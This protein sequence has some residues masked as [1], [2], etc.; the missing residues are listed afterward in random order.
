MVGPNDMWKCSLFSYSDSCRR[1]TPTGMR[2][3][4]DKWDK[5]NK[6]NVG[7]LT[8]PDPRV[9]RLWQALRP[10][11][12]DDSCLRLDHPRLRHYVHRT[13]VPVIVQWSIID[14]H[15]NTPPPLLLLCIYY[16]G[17]LTCNA[18]GC[19]SVDSLLFYHFM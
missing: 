12:N 13:A 14:F 11:G 9:I 15:P 1:K 4:V 7:W 17:S 16:F 5:F 10:S 6:K 19:I 8:R 2:E 3:T 18:L